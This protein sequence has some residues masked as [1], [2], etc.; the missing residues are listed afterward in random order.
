MKEEGEN[1][2]VGVRQGW[3]MASKNAR[4]LKKTKKTSKVKNLVFFHLLVKFY[5]YDL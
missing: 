5:T 2:R 3:K 1:R 4:F